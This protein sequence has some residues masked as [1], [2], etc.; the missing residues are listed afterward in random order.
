MT[1]KP[2]PD[3]AERAFRRRR[4]YDAA[5]ILPIFGIIMLVSPVFGIFTK[6]TLLFGAPLPFLYVFSVWFLLIL[7]ARRMSHLLSKGEERS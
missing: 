1:L 5:L 2:A 6:N 3:L 7:L 4:R